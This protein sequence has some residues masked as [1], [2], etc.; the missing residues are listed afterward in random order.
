VRAL[1]LKP[2]RVR[3]SCEG[4]KREAEKK[5]GRDVL[6]HDGFEGK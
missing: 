3:I 5:E 6:V 4:R 1:D 2:M